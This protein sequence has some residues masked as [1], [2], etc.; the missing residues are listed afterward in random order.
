MQVELEARHGL[1]IESPLSYC[2]VYLL[3]DPRLPIRSPQGKTEQRVVVHCIERPGR[4]M[5][6]AVNESKAQRLWYGL[7]GYRGARDGEQAHG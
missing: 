3:S 6:N 4:W 1:K 2:P 7:Q 5:G